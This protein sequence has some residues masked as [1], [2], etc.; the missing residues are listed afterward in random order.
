MPKSPNEFAFTV[1]PATLTAVKSEGKKHLAMI[2][3]LAALTLLVWMVAHVLCFAHCN[4]GGTH[5]AAETPT[6]AQS[7]CCP[8]S[9]ASTDA[10]KNQPTTSCL[11]LKNTLHTGKTTLASLADLSVVL[12]ST[13]F[14][15]S[16]TTL[17]DESADFLV[18]PSKAA[19]PV[20]TPEVCLG[21]AFRSIPPPVL[22]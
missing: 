13:V 4:L 16:A 18:T 2:Q 19:E 11:T 17:A 5:A 22:A 1:K 20:T 21:P 8:K 7:G 10:E 14:L 15:I 3:P 9:A 12:P 6:L